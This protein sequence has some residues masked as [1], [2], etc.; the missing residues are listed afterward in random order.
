MVADDEIERRW[1]VAEAEARLFGGEREIV[2]VGRFEIRERLGR[3]GLG[4]VYAAF[5]PELDRV[6]ALKLMRPD[7]STGD[8]RE[9]M[10]REARAMARLAHPNVVPVYEVGYD[11][12]RVFLAMERVPG[13]SARA[14]LATRR[15]WR[16]IV[17]VF[18]Q[19]GR[20]LAAA[21]AAKLVHRDFKPDNVLVGDDGRARVADFGMAGDDAGGTPAYMSPEQRAGGS[22]GPAADQYAFAVSLREALAGHDAPAR[23]ATTLDR[24]LAER[25]EDRWPTL[26]D[27]LDVLE[28]PPQRRVLRIAVRS[29]IVVVL[30]CALVG[31]ILQMWMFRDWMNAR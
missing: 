27:L 19:A 3:G 26:T 15:S 28:N 14:W 24:A 21:H 7:R 25:P 13:R 22:V 10:L 5:D 9:R 8:D 23:I 4:V 11:D 29:L 18:V 31:A 1:I 30:L 17:R 16:E 20:G 12:G 2:R 6:V